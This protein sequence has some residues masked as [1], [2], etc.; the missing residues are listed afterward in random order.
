[1]S[2]WPVVVRELSGRTGW[3]EERMD[4]SPKN[5]CFG[6]NSLYLQ[7]PL[8]RFHLND[9]GELRHTKSEYVNVGDLLV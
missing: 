5:E 6:N 7:I 9:F 2:E 4:R 8:G 3:I 1:M